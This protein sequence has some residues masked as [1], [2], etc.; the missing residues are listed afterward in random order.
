MSGISRNNRAEKK[1]QARR[2]AR[3]PAWDERRKEKRITRGLKHK[4]SVLQTLV[5]C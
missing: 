3:L 5:V 2:E 1:E 4:D